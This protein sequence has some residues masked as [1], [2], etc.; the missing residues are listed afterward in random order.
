MAEGKLELEFS[1]VGARTVLD[2]IALVRKNA[3]AASDMS[4]GIARSTQKQGALVIATKRAATEADKKAQAEKIAAN[5]AERAATANE[6]SANASAR[7]NPATMAQTSGGIA[8]GMTR[9]NIQIQGAGEFRTSSELFSNS[10]RAAGVIMAGASLA[11]GD[12]ANTF[13]QAA[14]K[15]ASFAGMGWGIGQG[16]GAKGGMIGAAFG[17]GW[18]VGSELANWLYQ[19]E[20]ETEEGK[21][22]LQRLRDKNKA[23]NEARFEQ[24][25]FDRTLSK[26][27]TADEAKSLVSSLEDQLAE[28]RMKF[29]NGLDG[30]G[31]MQERQAK[32]TAIEN[33]LKAAQ[34]IEANLDRKERGKAYE[35]RL[36]RISEIE[37]NAGTAAEKQNWQNAFD[38]AS[39][40]RKIEMLN[41]KLVENARTLSELNDK[42]MSSGMTDEEF[43]T[44]SDRYR[45]AQDEK[46]SLQNQIR[47]QR[48]ELEKERKEAAKK[49][50]EESKAALD[51]RAGDIASEYNK[52]QS[53]YNTIGTELQRAGIAFGGTA[54]LQVSVLQATAESVK[55][56]LQ[57]IETGTLDVAVK[58]KQPVV[59]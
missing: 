27:S 11:F 53:G 36:N 1:S 57:I 21:A 48:L 59:S 30:E 4:P 15:I 2:T 34:E 20:N 49:A 33:R 9:G 28:A 32:I 50:A 31:T 6:R 19:D 52:A 5:A 7:T 13:N 22:R 17:I 47:K 8:G 42:F 23:R 55:S 39:S 3:E 12:A 37:R 54:S 51:K 58:N 29:E 43:Q 41:A 35:A 16:F 26:V 18:G 25:K 10:I 38:E 14:G 24:A 44:Y 56:I 40:E 45:T 46:V